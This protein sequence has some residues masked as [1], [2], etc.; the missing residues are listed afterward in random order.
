MS[1]KS[2]EERI[3]ELESA[4]QIANLKAKYGHACDAGY[5]AVAIADLFTEDGVWDGGAHGEFVGRDAIRTFF[6]GASDVYSFAVHWFT[7]PMIE[8]D[9]DEGR[10]T[11]YLFM[12]ATTSEEQ[13]PVWNAARYDDEFVRRDGVWYFRRLQLRH[14]FTT[15]FDRGWVDRPSIR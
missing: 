10:G 8:V 6:E 12:A 11:W 7:N 13:M 9:G 4:H 14:W 1:T 5:D 15:P 2:L 3:R